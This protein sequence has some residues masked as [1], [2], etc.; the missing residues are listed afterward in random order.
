MREGTISKDRSNVD[1]KFKG[2][3]ENTTPIAEPNQQRI[4]NGYLFRFNLVLICIASVY[5]H[6][7][8][9]TKTKAVLFDA[10]ERF[11]ILPQSCPHFRD[12]GR[13]RVHRAICGSRFSWYG[14]SSLR[15]YGLKII[16]TEFSPFCSWSA[17]CWSNFRTVSTSKQNL[18]ACWR[19]Q[20]EDPASVF[21][22]LRIAVW[23]GFGKIFE[24]SKTQRFITQSDSCK[25]VENIESEQR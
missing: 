16:V 14:G 17:K 4:L 12:S 13:A 21:P 1:S 9:F 15:D 11:S 19:N 2:T 7:K 25:E 20:V 5:Y 3:E 22:L 24:L 10:S 18:F 8:R 6:T 23:P